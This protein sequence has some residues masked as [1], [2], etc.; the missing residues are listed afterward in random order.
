MYTTASSLVA[1]A[2]YFWR[3]RTSVLYGN[4]EKFNIEAVNDYL[5]I[6]DSIQIRI[7]AADSIQDS[8][9]TEIPDLQVS[10]SCN[11]CC[12]KFECNYVLYNDVIFNT[13]K[14]GNDRFRSSLWVLFLLKFSL[15]YNSL[16]VNSDKESE[17]LHDVN[18]LNIMWIITVYLFRYSDITVTLVLGK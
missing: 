5:P 10:T 2:Q 14:L 8:I 18:F 3:I 11:K 15:L 16:N 1:I 13:Y 12:R 6:Q 4:Q 17:L 9:Q 7:A